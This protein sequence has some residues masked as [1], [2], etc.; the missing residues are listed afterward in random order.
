M[1][2]TL[3]L[4]IVAVLVMLAAFPAMAQDDP[5]TI[6]DIVVASAS[7]EPAEFS[8]LLTAVQAADPVVLEVLSDPEQELTVFAPTDA[9]F[10]ECG[11]DGTDGHRETRHDDGSQRE[12]CVLCHDCSPFASPSPTRIAAP[13]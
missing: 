4:L 1:R 11:T 7:G 5:G 2:K 12:N 8:T 6:A 10:A 9:A 3:S 13:T